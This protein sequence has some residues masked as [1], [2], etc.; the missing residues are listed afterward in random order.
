MIG[1]PKY[2]YGDKVRIKLNDRTLEGTI[3]II[4]RFGTFFD[5]SNVHYDIMCET[6]DGPLLVKHA[7]EDEV[8]LV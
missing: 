1:K 4:D 3:E 5:K 2:K 7:R 6:E 8:E